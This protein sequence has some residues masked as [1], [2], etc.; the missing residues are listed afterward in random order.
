LHDLLKLKKSL[1]TDLLESYQPLL[2]ELNIS[3]SDSSS[4]ATSN[5]KET[6]KQIF[7]DGALGGRVKTDKLKLSDF[8]DESF[9]EEVEAVSHKQA[10]GNASK[11]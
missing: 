6:M 9:F 4:P 8:I 2:A 5:N 7:M 10:K 11:Q 3:E 1:Y